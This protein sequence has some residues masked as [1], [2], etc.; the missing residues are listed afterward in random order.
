MRQ[1]QTRSSRPVLAPALVVLTAVWMILS[2][3]SSS[4]GSADCQRLD[5][6][7]PNLEAVSGSLLVEYYDALQRDR[8]LETFRQ[9]VSARYGQTALGRLLSSPS[10]EARRARCLRSA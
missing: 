6:G 10:V 4:R 7:V 8:D 3:S 2:Q 1:R 5:G 9:K